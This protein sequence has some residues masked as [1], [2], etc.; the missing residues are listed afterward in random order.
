[1]ALGGGGDDRRVRRRRR[2]PAVPHRLHDRQHPEV[3]CRSERLFVSRAVE[4]P[5]VSEIEFRV[6]PFCLFVFIYIS[7]FLKNYY[8]VYVFCMF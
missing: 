6:G 7:I 5:N 3:I 8:H 1:M 4:A 2:Q